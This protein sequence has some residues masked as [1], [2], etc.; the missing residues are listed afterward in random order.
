[1]SKVGEELNMY[2]MSWHSC[3][4]VLPQ[5]ERANDSF[6]FYDIDYRVHKDNLGKL[7]TLKAEEKCFGV[8]IAK[9]VRF[10]AQIRCEEVEV[11]VRKLQGVRHATL[12]EL[13]LFVH[14]FIA[15]KDDAQTRAFY[16]GEELRFL[17]SLNITAMGSEGFHGTMT[18]SPD[19]KLTFFVTESGNCYFRPDSLI[20]LIYT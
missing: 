17:S 15:K 4:E 9:L 14:S 10:P 5:P 8:N 3:H 1:M 16:P 18:R 13:L 2:G 11:A 6:H 20:L 19:R 7:L 12:H